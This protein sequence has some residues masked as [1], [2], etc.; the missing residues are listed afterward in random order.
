[1]ESYEMPIEP[2]VAAYRLSGG[3]APNAVLLV[4]PNPLDMIIVKDANEWTADHS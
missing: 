1:M 4:Y 2:Q 3:P